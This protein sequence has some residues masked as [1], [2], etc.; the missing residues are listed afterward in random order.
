VILAAIDEAVGAGARLSAACGLVG[1]SA[2]T[3]QRW[4]LRPAG[5]DLRQAPRRRLCNA[6]TDEET[7]Q[8]LAVMTSPRYATL[9]PKQIVPLLADKGLLFAKTPSA[10]NH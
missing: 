6:L 3:V 5:D 10:W 1:L 2:R 9:S 4:K 8:V 7:P